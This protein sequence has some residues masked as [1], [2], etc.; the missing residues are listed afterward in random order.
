MQ[1]VSSKL[2]SWWQ[3]KNSAKPLNTQA[4]PEEIMHLFR[5]RREHSLLQARFNG[6][7]DV[8]QSLLLEVDLEQNQLLLDE[9]FPHRFPVQYWVGRRI[10][11]STSEGGLATRFESRV[12][13]SMGLDQGNAL[14][15]E[16][17]RSIMA[18]QRR[19]SFRVA[20]SGRMPV[21]AVVW[22]PEQGNLAVRVLDLSASGI[23]LAIPGELDALAQDTRLALRLGAETP[24]VS[25]LSVRYMQPSQQ[26][27]D[28]T[29]VG[30]QFT[31]MNSSQCKV[32]ERFL[33]RMQRSQ[34]QRELEAGL[35]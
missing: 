12:S 23:R 16:M 28:C 24:L 9:P 22:V 8:F 2:K 34:R 13:A 32:I 25:Q 7:D 33:V 18:A 29:E 30:A 3:Q 14:V 20:V 21:D 10:V 1:R 17:P 6:V 11:V 5:L 4:V 15:L 35:V 31:G 26:E 19:N 27:Q